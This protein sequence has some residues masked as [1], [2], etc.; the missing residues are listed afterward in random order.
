VL[1][2]LSEALHDTGVH[3]VFTN[4]YGDVTKGAMFARVDAAVGSDEASKI[5]SA[6]H[7]CAHTRYALGTGYPPQTHCGV[8]FGCLV[9]RAAFNSAGLKDRT[10]YLSCVIPV[11]DQPAHLRATSSSEIRTIKYAASR[12]I[13]PA[14][15]L[16]MGLPASMPISDAIQIATEGLKELAAVIDATP[17]LARIR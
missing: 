3:G 5:L 15:L 4:V 10:V 13:S 9:R 14:E 2:Q 1:S 7:S 11:G 16:A 6:S 8:C 12:G 17:D